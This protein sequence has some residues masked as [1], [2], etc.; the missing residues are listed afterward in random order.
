[1]TEINPLA[2]FSTCELSDALIKLGNLTGGHIPNLRMISPSP[3]TASG[4]E[5][6]LCGPAFTVKMVH[7]SET[8]APKLQGHFADMIEE[9]SVVFIAA[10]E[11]KWILSLCDINS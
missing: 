2:T 6:R 10:P 11:G 7:T 4:E 5:T 3:A 9:G 8:D 1:M